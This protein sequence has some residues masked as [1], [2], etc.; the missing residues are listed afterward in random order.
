MLLRGIVNE[1]EEELTCCRRRTKVEGR[2]WTCRMLRCDFGLS[3][4]DF[5]SR[6]LILRASDVTT[7]I[8]SVFVS[9]SCS[10]PTEVEEMG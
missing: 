3:E 6:N 10:S 1:P 9:T 7:S 4:V 5:A 2:R 8:N